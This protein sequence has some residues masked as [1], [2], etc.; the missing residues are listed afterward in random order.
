M[1][2]SAKART[3][4][5]AFEASKEGNSTLLSVVSATST[6]LGLLDIFHPWVP[7][8]RLSTSLVDDAAYSAI[9]CA[10]QHFCCDAIARAFA[11]NHPARILR[12]TAPCGG[13]RGVAVLLIN[14]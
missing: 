5:A 14:S 1:P 9:F 13:R 12:V 8:R 3:W 11:I 7:R 4:S 6:V 2:F 10:V